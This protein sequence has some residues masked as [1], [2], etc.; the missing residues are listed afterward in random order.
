MLI[1][2]G[3]EKNLL[4][5]S[6]LNKHGRIIKGWAQIRL[7][8]KIRCLALFQCYTSRHLLKI[9]FSCR[10]ILPYVLH[11]NI[12]LERRFCFC[13]LSLP[14]L[15][16][17][18]SMLHVFAS[19]RLRNSIFVWDYSPYSTSFCGWNRAISITTFCAVFN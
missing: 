2:E 14:Q 15:L 18:T 7:P 11:L 10:H 13:Y 5:R 19:T 4:L 16:T 6:Y 3:E 8:L 12:S 17:Y 1:V 9:N